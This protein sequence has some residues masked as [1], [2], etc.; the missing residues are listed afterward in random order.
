MIDDDCHVT[1]SR[2]SAQMR[3][4]D[5]HG[6]NLRVD[7][8]TTRGGPDCLDYGIWKCS[9]S[10]PWGNSNRMYLECPDGDAALVLDKV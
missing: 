1:S 9:Y 3:I 5:I 2:C 10:F 7:A 8:Y 6:D 4:T